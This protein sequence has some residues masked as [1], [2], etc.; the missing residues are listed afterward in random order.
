MFLSSLTN[1]L[2]S[3]S[4]SPSFVHSNIIKRVADAKHCAKHWILRRIKHSLCL[5]RIMPLYEQVERIQER[6]AY[7]LHIIGANNSSYLPQILQ[8]QIQDLGSPLFLVIA[9]L[10]QLAQL[11]LCGCQCSLQNTF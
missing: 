8:Q 4:I 3:H 9:K 2:L 6:L 1:H 11:S 5:L 10:L 7:S